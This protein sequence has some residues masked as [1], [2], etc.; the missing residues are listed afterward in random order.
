MKKVLALIL[1]LAVIIGAVKGIIYY[2]VTQQLDH[3]IALVSPFALITYKGVSS[4]LVG[5]VN[6]KGLKI[7]AYGS[8]MAITVDDIG[9]KFSDLIAL[10]FVGEDLKKQ[11]LPEQMKLT[12]RHVKVDLQSL[13]PYMSLLG[14]QSQQTIYDYTLLGCR[15][16][17]AA[18]PLD[19]LQQLGYSR[20]ALS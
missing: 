3:A 6:V 16:L 18:P 13:Q 15:E 7:K 11:R 4:S 12:L 17:Q 20:M 1:L 19:A 2:K 8:N 5:G 9:V 14:A 10:L